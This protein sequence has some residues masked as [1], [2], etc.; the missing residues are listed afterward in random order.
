MAIN[1]TA[2]IR[3]TLPADG[4]RVIFTSIM[5]D[6][7]FLDPNG[8]VTRRMQGQPGEGHHEIGQER[9]AEHGIVPKDY[10]DVYR[11]MFRLKYVRVVEHDD[12]TTIEV[13][14]GPDLTAA[15]ERAVDQ[16]RRAGKRVVQT[17][18]K[19]V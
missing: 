15:Q 2:G 18:A 7:Y 11:Q 8:A 5:P 9:L 6:R 3:H 13:E 10:A 12:N 17:R 16:F 4:F 14:H 1:P 19:I